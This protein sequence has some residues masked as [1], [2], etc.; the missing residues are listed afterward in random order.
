MSILICSRHAE[1]ILTELLVE[2]L[3]KQTGSRDSEVETL[4]AAEA[5]YKLPFGLYFTL[6]DQEI[7]VRNSF[8]KNGMF[9]DSFTVRTG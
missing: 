5:K 3:F 7:N 8:L 6:R 2:L 1:N 9:R 4:D